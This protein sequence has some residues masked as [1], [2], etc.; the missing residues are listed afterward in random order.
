LPRSSSRGLFAC[1]RR[2]LSAATAERAAIDRRSFEHPD[3]LDEPPAT[4]G[5][6][7][8]PP[9]PLLVGN[10][11]EKNDTGLVWYDAGVLVAENTWWGDAT[12]PT[13]AANPAGTGDSIQSL[14]GGTVDYTPWLAA[15]PV[16][17][18]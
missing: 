4:C 2:E 1:G 18:P 15:E 8:Y 17:C 16:L 9:A 14:G 11:V 13:E 6:G 5:L 3:A 10:I 7:L 12:G